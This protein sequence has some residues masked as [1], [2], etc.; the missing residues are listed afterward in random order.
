MKR[1]KILKMSLVNISGNLV[2]KKK[3]PTRLSINGGFK[4]SIKMG[5]EFI[6]YYTFRKTLFLFLLI[7]FETNTDKKKL[8]NYQFFL[9]LLFYNKFHYIRYI[10]EDVFETLSEIVNVWVWNR[11]W[12][13]QRYRKDN[14]DANSSSILFNL[15]MDTFNFQSW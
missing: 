4:S 15:L 5:R 9:L 11:H 8:S 14:G 1:N 12:L 6:I 3:I 10:H 7:H 13:N 2:L